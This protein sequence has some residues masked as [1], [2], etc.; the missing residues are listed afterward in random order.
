MRNHEGEAVPE[1]DDLS[2]ADSGTIR[3]S[4]R[5]AALVVT[6][7]SR[8]GPLH[9]SIRK[10]VAALEENERAGR[11]STRHGSVTEADENQIKIEHPV[12][13]L[14]QGSDSERR[15]RRWSVGAVRDGHDLGRQVRGRA[16]AARPRSIHRAPTRSGRVARVVASRRTCDWLLLHRAHHRAHAAGELSTQPPRHVLVVSAQ[17]CHAVLAKALRQAPSHRADPRRILTAIVGRHVARTSRRTRDVALTRCRRRRRRR[18]RRPGDSR[19]RRTASAQLRT[20]LRRRIEPGMLSCILTE[21][22]TRRAR[23][24]RAESVRRIGRPAHSRAGPISW[25]GHT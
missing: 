22:N 4:S 19:T 14:F 2:A 9:H 7:S 12:S 8:L 10:R 11:A 24:D 5:E 18:G 1:L 20:R 3:P 15:Q 6:D 21:P 25:L 16:R 23:P 13:S 17:R